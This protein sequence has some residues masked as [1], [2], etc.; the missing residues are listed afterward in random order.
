LSICIG[1]HLDVWTGSLVVDNCIESI[2]ELL[3]VVVVFFEAGVVNTYGRK[4]FLQPFEVL[5]QSIGVSGFTIV[6]DMRLVRIQS[7]L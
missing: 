5:L 4:F 2:G 7:S 6:T 1:F 3:E